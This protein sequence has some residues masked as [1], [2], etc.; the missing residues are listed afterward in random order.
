MLRC[1]KFTLLT[2]LLTMGNSRNL[3]DHEGFLE[4]FSLQVKLRRREDK[5]RPMLSWLIEKWLA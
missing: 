2:D 4:V 3:E 5:H 1:V